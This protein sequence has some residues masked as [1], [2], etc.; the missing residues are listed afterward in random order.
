MSRRAFENFGTA[1]ERADNYTIAASRYL[2]QMKEE[3]YI[4]PD[5]IEKLDITP[6]DICLDIGCGTGNILI[7]L[8][9]SV[10]SITGIDH[11]KCL[12]VLKK[13]AAGRGNI[14]LIPGNFLDIAVKKTFDKIIVYSVLQYLANIKELFYFID[15]AV[16]LLKPQGKLL[17]G[18]IPNISKEKRF[19]SSVKG[20]LYKKE[21][22]R[23]RIRFRKQADIESIADLLQDLE[24]DKKYVV[25]DDALVLSILAR[26]RKRGMDAY[27]LPHSG[28]LPFG[29]S[30]EDILIERTI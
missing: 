20:E 18:D 12:Q 22:D 3:R 19:F 6:D 14:N 5:I 4:I 2:C 25:L 26:A 11:P 29:A 30:R 23:K 15:K 17:L 9:P 16:S 10:R 27:V 13:R 7:P 1:A 21:W 24:K 28:R 8:A